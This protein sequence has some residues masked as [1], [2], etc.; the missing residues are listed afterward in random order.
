MKRM[1]LFLGALL[2][3]LLTAQL[4]FA[5]G[6]FKVGEKAP[7]FALTAITGEIVGLVPRLGKSSYFDCFISVTPVWYQGSALQNVSEMT[8]RKNVSVFGV[9]SSGNSKSSEGNR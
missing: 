5:E 9:N 8:K 1:I 6:L 3:P 4:V 2:V 7:S